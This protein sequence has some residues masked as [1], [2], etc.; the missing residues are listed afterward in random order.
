VSDLYKVLEF[1][2]KTDSDSRFYI[3]EYVI[4]EDWHGHIIGGPELVITKNM[5]EVIKKV[6][7][8]R[9]GRAYSECHLDIAPM[10]MPSMSR[11]AV[12]AILK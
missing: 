10:D 3:N 4:G 8:Q 11:E 1:V 9:S 12:A 5:L 2:S 7:P 6:S